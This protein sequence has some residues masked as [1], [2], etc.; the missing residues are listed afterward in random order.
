MLDLAI[1]GGTIIDGTG[2]PGRQG[3]VGVKD[4]RIVA[5][6]AAGH[7]DEVAAETFEADGLVVAPGF[8]DPHTHYDA[9]LFW[10]PLA[11]PSNVHGVTSVVAGNC[12]FTLAPLHAADADYLRRMMAKVEGMPLAALEHGVDWQWETFADYLG[13]LDGR[14]GLNAGFMV[15]HCALRRYVM[16]ADAVGNEATPAQVEAMVGLLH[17]S[18]DAG[19]LG[20]STTRS[21]SHSDGD[22]QPVASR[23]ASRDELLALCEAVGEHEG[24]FLEGAF[25]G[26][27]DK[28]SDDEID[29]VAAMSA[30]AGRSINWNVLTVDSAAPD[31]VPRQLEAADAAAAQ[32]GR[33][34]ALTMPVLVP[35]NMSFGTF[36]ALW[37]MPGWGEVMRLPPADKRARLADPEV[38]RALEAQSHS[39]AA[40]VFRRLAGWD[41]YVIGDT[42]SAANEGLTGRVVGD[43]AAERGQEAFDTLVEI[44]A[45]DD[46]RTVLWPMPTDNDDESWRMRQRVWADPRVMLG[47]S[48]AGAHLDRMCGSTY[49]TRLL[50]DCLRGR[51]LATVER[52]VQMLTQAPAQ[53]FGLTGRGTLAEGN[54]ADLV[55]FDPETVGA[56][57]ARLVEDLPG[58]SARL[59]AGSAGMVRVY[60]AGEATVEHDKATGATPGRVLRSGRDTATVPTR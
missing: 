38:R 19:G 43:I 14:I 15:G 48:D 34:V 10:D 22:G 35:M 37:L 32:G 47:G 53:L 4:G 52:A 40:G 56:E 60:V 18:I 59:T 28:F 42:Y 7:L 54:H 49:T 21:S 44:V 6:G 33:V 20:L 23:H 31:R 29:L 27:L 11:S 30:A 12:G 2:S 25:E 26:G 5:V 24:T 9:Q 45:H 50:A 1:R 39:E 55:V 3:D 46:F 58:G 8:I 51:R 57:S 41:R 17:E 16:G 13:R 36:C